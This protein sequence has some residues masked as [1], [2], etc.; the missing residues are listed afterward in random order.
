MHHLL[1]RIAC[2]VIPTRRALNRRGIEVEDACG[3]CNG[4]SETSEHLFIA[5]EV[6]K[7]CWRIAEAEDLVADAEMKGEDWRSWCMETI[8]SARD[9][10][11]TAM[12]AVIW[13]LWKERKD[14][15]WEKCSKPEEV[16][17]KLSFKAIAEWRSAAG[18]RS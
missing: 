3:L 5:C 7:R 18:R 4:T 12:V 8:R 11:L 2:G 14:R 6:A 9:D 10:K 17:M 1:W 13:G 16:F 15:V